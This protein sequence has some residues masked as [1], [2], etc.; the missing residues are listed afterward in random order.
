M[1]FANLVVSLAVLL[2]LVLVVLKEIKEIKIM[3]TAAQAL[4][5]LQALLATL[6]ADVTEATADIADLIEQVSA[7]NGLN[8]TAVEAVV[9][10]GNAALASLQAS[11]ANANKIISPTGISVGIAPATVSLAPGATQKFTASVAGTTNLAVTWAALVGTIDQTGLYTAPSTPGTD[12]VT[13]TSQADTTKNSTAQVTIAVQVGIS[14]Q[15]S[16]TSAGPV[17]QGSTQQFTATVTGDPSNAGVTWTIAPTTGSG[18]VDQTGLFT[19][20]SV[21]GGSAVVTATSVTDTTKSG[22]AN[23]TF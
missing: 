14:V 22:S 10:Q 9:T 19:P 7:L 1:G 13:V 21:A 18:T 6:V 5:D 3:A 23:V 15:V 8:P 20:P 12:T 11:I 17:A 2:T 16:P 4:T